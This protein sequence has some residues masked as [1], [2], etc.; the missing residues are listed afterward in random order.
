MTIKDLLVSGKAA[1]AEKD[2]GPVDAELILAHLL[3]VTRMDMHSRVIEKS[4][5]ELEIISEQ[6]H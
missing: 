2:I 4:N 6:F 3:G 1:L 5:D